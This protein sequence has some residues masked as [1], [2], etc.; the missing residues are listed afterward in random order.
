MRNLYPDHLTKRQTLT[1]VVVSA[2]LGTI[3]L[4]VYEAQ[5]PV[6]D[7]EVEAATV[8]L[9]QFP[10]LEWL[11]PSQEKVSVLLNEGTG[12][13]SLV[14]ATGQK[15]SAISTTNISPEIAAYYEEQFTKKGFEQIK[16]YGDP[17]TDKYW[18][19]RYRKDR[20]Y[21]EVQ[22]YPTPYETNSFT[23]VLFFGILPEGKLNI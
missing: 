13:E 22:Y 7:S 11:K 18:V 17:K 23:T 10:G 3:P 4:F 14:L 21:S 8:V 9:K 5:Q 16:S 2:I 12:E 6:T 1:I 20:Q 19:K 15:S